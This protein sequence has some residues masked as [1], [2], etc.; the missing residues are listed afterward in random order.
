MQQED[1]WCLITNERNMI[2]TPW[3]LTISLF[4]ACSL[5]V[6]CHIHRVRGSLV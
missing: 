1:A 3:D 6:H 2:L 5:S 4:T